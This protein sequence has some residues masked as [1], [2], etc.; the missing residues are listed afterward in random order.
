MATSR[1]VFALTALLV[2]PR[3]SAAGVIRHDVAD[4]E[5]L[6]LAAQP[7][8]AS[9]GRLNSTQSTGSIVSSGTLIAPNI[10]LTAAHALSGASAVSFSVGGNNYT[11]SQWATYP[12]W[13]GDLIAGYDIGIIQL[14]SLVSDVAPA[15]RYTGKKEIGKT[16]TVVGYGMTGTGLT[17]AVD[18]DRQKRAGTNRIDSTSAGS[19]NSARLLW[20]DFDSP[21]SSGKH[22][23]T[24]LEYLTARGDSGGGL[25]ID[26]SAGM[27]LAGVTSFGYSRDGLADAS[28]GEQSAF[29]RVEA[30]NRWIDSMIQRFTLP[31]GSLAELAARP[32][33]RAHGLFSPVPEPA[34]ATLAAIACMVLAGLARRR[35][36][37]A[38]W[39]AASH[40]DSLRRL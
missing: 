39:Q 13:S 37:A 1:L 34:S 15:I 20:M 29:T 26:T 38:I 40:V 6:N 12:S 5:Y 17:G 14:N 33:I 32:G 31:S 25:F 30:F 10:V 11:A 19:G 35:R 23:A 8:F 3:V 21:T 18:Y 22:G 16:A 2:L 7:E 4:R 27:R 24:A 28:Y 36:S 9:V